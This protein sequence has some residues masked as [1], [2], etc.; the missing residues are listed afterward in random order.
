MNEILQEISHFGGENLSWLGGTLFFNFFLYA[1]STAK[2][3]LSLYRISLILTLI[4]EGII[5]TYLYSIGVFDFWLLCGYFISACIGVYLT[6][7]IVNPFFE[8]KTYKS[9]FISFYGKYYIHKANLNTILGLI[10]SIYACI[11]INF[12]SNHLFLKYN[13]LF[14]YTLWLLFTIKKVIVQN[15][16]IKHYQQT[17]KLK[18]QISNEEEAFRIISVN[19]GTDTP[20]LAISVLTNDFWI[21]SFS[22]ILLVFRFKLSRKNFGSFDARNRNSLI[23]TVSDKQGQNIFLAFFVSLLLAQGVDA[24]TYFW[25]VILIFIWNFLR[26]NGDNNFDHYTFLSGLSSTNFQ[27]NFYDSLLNRVKVDIH[28]NLIEKI[29]LKKK[30][31]YGILFQEFDIVYFSSVRKGEFIDK[32]QFLIP[33]N[34]CGIHRASH[35]LLIFDDAKNRNNLFTEKAM[36]LALQNPTSIIDSFNYFVERDPDSSISDECHNFWSKRLSILQLLCDESYT[37]FQFESKEHLERSE[38]KSV[39]GNLQKLQIQQAIQHLSSFESLRQNIRLYELEFSQNDK[40]EKLANLFSCGIF[41]FNTLFRQLHE[42]PSIPSRF[43]DLLNVAECI[44]RYIVGFCFAERIEDKYDLGSHLTFETKAISFGTCT[45]YLS[46]WKNQYKSQDI[47]ILGNSINS[48]LNVRYQ[49]EE[50]IVELIKFLKQLNPNKQVKYSRKPDMIELLKWI[51]FIRNKTR[52]HG[53]PSKVDYQFYLC[54]EKTILFILSSATEMKIKPCFRAN[55]NEFN[56][57]IDLSKGGLPVIVP[58]VEKFEDEIHFNPYL[59]K[60]EIEEMKQRHYEI[61]DNIKDQQSGLFISISDGGRTEWWHCNNHFK[62]N[63]GIVYVINSRSDENDSWISFSTGNIL[64]P[65]L[66]D[67]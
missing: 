29:Y 35:F 13:L 12:F 53:T 3:S 26:F 57:T 34:D 66:I 52:G 44:S 63:N 17:S 30:W 50:N 43:I 56:W 8:S 7:T 42:S 39:T 36:Y 45:D 14:L 54:L 67:E 55:F 23:T 61:L 58:F 11:A 6:L 64:R 37:K 15:N 5:D 22:L 24:E 10:I 4:C 9:N 46:R 41:E 49:D 33:N 59:E 28:Q 65:T 2:K 62:I 60:N 31:N 18:N 38:I 19:L 1:V 48:F 20:S 40:Q 51:V 47:S 25:A 21:I 27:S 16:L 32:E